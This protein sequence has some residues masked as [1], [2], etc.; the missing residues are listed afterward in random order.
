M[1]S[2]Q[3]WHRSIITGQARKPAAIAI[4]A[5]LRLASHA[6]SIGIRTRNILYDTGVLPVRRIGLPV[7]S[8][9]N[10]TAGGTGKT[11]MV[12]WLC[13][14][15]TDDL[16]I[17]PS[18]IAILTRGYKTRAKKQID[19]PSLLSGACPGVAILVDPDR[20]RAARMAL[21][22]GLQVI[23]MDD[24][25]QHR[26]LH[27]DM[28]I[29]MIDGT[30]PFGYGRLLPAGLLR[31][32]VSEIRRAKAAVITRSDLVKPGQIQQIE[33][34]LR[35][36]A[37]G[38]LIARAIHRPIQV[39]TLA[40]SVIKAHELSGMKVYAFCGIGNPDAFLATLRAL[41]AYLV[42]TQVFDDHHHFT[43]DQINQIC[44]D[45]LRSGARLIVT[46]EKNWLGL[47]QAWFRPDLPAGYLQVRLELVHCQK[48]LLQLIGSVLSAYRP[49]GQSSM[50]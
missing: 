37:P 40:G 36:L 12:V 7:I 6:Y 48:A 25:F 3:Q 50:V 47:E 8:I 31:E 2:I 20:A 35:A 49:A 41:G 1:G 42:G 16:G 45:A 26:R 19:E 38:L 39:K 23:V 46:T 10:I 32:P 29:L 27:R 11:P 9:G 44:E 13:K 4:S 34:S 21:K 17:E 14:R 28:D 33:R 15:L 43:R 5:C 18:A 22:Q 24:G 30:C